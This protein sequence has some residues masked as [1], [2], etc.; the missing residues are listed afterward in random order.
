MAHLLTASV[1]L[2]PVPLVLRPAAWAV[3]SAL[4][5]ATIATMPRWMREM[6]GL[7]Q[8]RAE[9]TLIV[10]LMKAAFGMAA[11]NPHLALLLL[12]RISPSTVPVAAPALLGL[13]AVNPETTTP[14]LARQRL[15]FAKPSEA[16]LE[17]RAR[18]R[19]RVFD[20][21]AA[22]SDDGITESEPIL[23]SIT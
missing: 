22:P 2:P 4:R 10:P 13:Q 9:D 1:L 14:E 20:E 15:G 17:F 19:A 12:R 5:T 23:G 3:S 21:G 8:S 6:A 11:L 18:Q 16:H 7:R